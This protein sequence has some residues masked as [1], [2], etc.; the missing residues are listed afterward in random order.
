MHSI[1]KIITSFF[2]AILLLAF[3]GSP[4]VL[5]QSQ[6]NGIALGIAKINQLSNGKITA[7]QVRVPDSTKPNAYVT[8]VKL[9]PDDDIRYR[10]SGFILDLKN[11]EAAPSSKNGY[12]K[13]Y[14]GTEAADDKFIA[15]AGTNLPLKDI[16]DK[17]TEGPNTIML[18]VVTNDGKPLLPLTEIT[19][20]F[21]YT[22]EST[23]P[24]IDIVSPKQGAIL[25]STINQDFD[26][27]TPN[28]T[29]VN[30]PTARATNTSGK[31]SIYWDEVKP[32]K[33]IATIY[34]NNFKSTDYDF[35]KIEDGLDRKLIFVLKDSKDNEFVPSIRSTLN[36]KSNFKGTVDIG[37]PKVTIVSPDK[38]ATNIDLKESDKIIVKIDNFILE[39]NGTDKVAEDGKGVLQV[40]IDGKKLP[41]IITKSE[42]SLGELNV[43]VLEKGQKEIS[44]ELVSKN[45][46]K[47]NPVAS[48]SIKFN[49]VPSVDIL[50]SDENLASQNDAQNPAWK[51]VI[52]VLIV[53]LIIGGIAV[54]ITKA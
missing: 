27:K 12:I 2:V 54:L 51:I 36:I 7:V 26:I 45:F 20:T 38:S 17:L 32:E 22:S 14:T 31:M 25:A 52:V 42:F 21:E 40:S 4:A 44:V 15:N 41:D 6:T 29:L 34:Q 37:L 43:G 19:L 49:F 18:Q 1:G 48:D 13:V 5:A 30:D 35:S 47:L 39:D 10:W 46:E 9:T 53:V 50:T 3:S 24:G 28:F 11:V 16:K 33:L 8:D 23:L